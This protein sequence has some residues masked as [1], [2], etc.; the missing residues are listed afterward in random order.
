MGFGTPSRAPRCARARPMVQTAMRGQPSRRIC[1]HSSSRVH[2]GRSHP[3]SS[4]V[5]RRSTATRVRNGASTSAVPCCAVADP[6]GRRPQRFRSSPRYA[7]PLSA[8]S[9][10]PRPPPD[11]VRPRRAGRSRGNRT[12]VAGLHCAGPDAPTG[13]ARLGSY[14]V[15]YPCAGPLSL[16]CL[17]IPKPRED[18]A[19]SI[20]FAIWI[21]FRAR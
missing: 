14:E 5:P 1:R 9:P 12:A 2:V 20:F 10:G 17:A 11:Y 13:G 3:K 15:S 19:Y 4:G 16:G 8:R 6:T 21:E 18:P 7:P